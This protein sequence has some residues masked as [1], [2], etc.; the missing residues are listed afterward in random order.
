MKLRILFLLFTLGGGSLFA[1][2]EMGTNSLNLESKEMNKT[3]SGGFDIPSGKTPSLTIPREP[4]EKTDNN[5]GKKEKEDFSMIDDQFIEF[6]SKLKPRLFT[7]DKEIKSEYGKDMYLGDV[8]TRGDKVVI[9]YRDHEY[10]DGDRIRVYVNGE[11]MIANVMLEAKFKG[12]DLE[13]KDGFNKIEFEA[14]NQG[15]SGP[16][17]AQMQILDENGS[18]I[19]NYEWNLLTG[20]K[21]TAIVVKKGL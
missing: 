2:I 1:Q 15:S 13:L 16:N 9:Q 11:M 18:V 21:A 6:E 3:T 20:N 5:L 10:V 19:A 7:K 8:S 14:L 4:R 17:T 12:F